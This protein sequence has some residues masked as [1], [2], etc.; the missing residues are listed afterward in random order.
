MAAL[1]AARPWLLMVPIL[2]SLRLTWP[3]WVLGGLCLV[4][5]AVTTGLGAESTQFGV[6]VLGGGWLLAS[7]TW[8]N[9]PHT[10]A[11]TMGKHNDH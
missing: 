6:A 11:R 5:L 7:R 8:I 4:G 10:G 3:S 1:D 9:P 2:I